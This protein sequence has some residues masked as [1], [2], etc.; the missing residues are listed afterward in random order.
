MNALYTVIENGQESSFRSNIAGG[1]SYPFYI[2]SYAERMAATVNQNYSMGEVSVTEMLPLM[3][4]NHNFPEDVQGERIFQPVSEIVAAEREAEMKTQ[5]YI[6]FGITLDFDNNKIRFVFNKNCPELTLP[7]MEIEI[8]SKDVMHIF[9]RADFKFDAELTDTENEELFYKAAL[10]KVAEHMEMQNTPIMYAELESFA[11]DK[12][13][14]LPLSIYDMASVANELK[15]GTID[16]CKINNGSI[17]ICSSYLDR[18]K[19]CCSISFTAL[20]EI[21][22]W[23]VSVRDSKDISPLKTFAA[24]MEADEITDINDALSVAM[25]IHNYDCI[26]VGNDEEYGHFVLYESCRDDIDM[27]FSEEVEDYIDFESYGQWRAEQDGAVSTQ[28][29][30]LIRSNDNQQKQMPTMNM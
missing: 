21:A 27:N 19:E 8:G 22:A 1:Y 12:T 17:E 2:Y 10:E 20:N 3:K 7:D 14:G 15:V 6:P 18:L 24:V 25:N 30:Y 13:I 16:E 28:Y 9:E 29:G 5:D 4:A 23:A 26:D 11:G